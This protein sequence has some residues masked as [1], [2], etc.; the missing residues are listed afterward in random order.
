MLV[1][2]IIMVW[3][4]WI[5]V[6]DPVRDDGGRAIPGGGLD[7]IGPGRGAHGRWATRGFVVA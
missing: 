3:T 1:I 5:V 2:T 6:L 7:V 4:A